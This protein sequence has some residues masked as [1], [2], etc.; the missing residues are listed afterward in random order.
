MKALSIG[1]LVEWLDDDIKSIESILH[2]ACGGDDFLVKE[3]GNIAITSGGKRIRPMLLIAFYKLLMEYYQKNTTTNYQAVL[4]SSAVLELI[5]LASLLHDDVIDEAT[6]RRGKKTAN[7]VWGNK[8]V[9]LVGDYLFAKSFEILC[10]VGNTDVLRVVSGASLGLTKGELRQLEVK[11]DLD[12][13]LEEYIRIVG[14]KTASLFKAATQ[15]AAILSNTSN[16]IMLKMA[17]FGFALGVAFQIVDDILDY[18]KTAEFGKIECGDFLEYKVTVPIIYAMQ[19]NTIHDKDIKFLQECFVERGA[20]K[21]RIGEVQNI[22]RKTGA[23][24]QSKLLAKEYVAK[25]KMCIEFLRDVKQ[26]KA[27][28][29]LLDFIVERTV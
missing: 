4:K 18:T 24:E 25:A 15:S 5:H 22:L 12:R 16:E 29:E 28:V 11:S 8:E 6:M 19:S 7:L 26:Y 13:T 2:E 10:E 27:I 3:V 14:L 23:I 21:E 20:T 9:I 1:R 17:E